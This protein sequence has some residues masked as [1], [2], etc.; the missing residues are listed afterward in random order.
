MKIRKYKLGEEEEIWNIFF[1]TTHHI[2]GRDYTKKQVAKW[3]PEDKNKDEWQQRLKE[4]Q[5]FVAEENGQL[6]G[7]AE[8]EPNG[9]ID[10]FYTHHEWI[11]KGVGKALYL[12]LEKEAINAN[13]KEIFAEVSLTA[14]EFFKSRGLKVIEEQENLV[15][16]EPAKRYIM[17]KDLN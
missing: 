15:C 1:N 11:G 9:H 6:V 3:A 14:L 12:Q 2:V 4:K 8:L 17:K 10:L 16:G 13:L 7:F 5:P